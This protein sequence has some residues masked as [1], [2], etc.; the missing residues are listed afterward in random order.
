MSTHFFQSGDQ[1]FPNASNFR[2]VSLAKFVLSYTID[3]LRPHFVMR[4][5]CRAYLI[6]ILF[7]VLD[8]KFHDLSAINSNALR[9]SVFFGWNSLKKL[10]RP[11][12]I[13]SVSLVLVSFEFHDA[14]FH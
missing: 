10:K 8:I 11:I 9:F 1:F 12:L 5:E 3:L 7:I 13:D 6:N 4:Y 14:H 2:R